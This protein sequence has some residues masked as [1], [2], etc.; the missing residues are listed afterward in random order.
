M[1][2]LSGRI[3]PAAA[4]AAAACFMLITLALPGTAAAQQA[5]TPPVF[6]ADQPGLSAGSMV[7]AQA[8]GTHTATS[9]SV[10]VFD[11]T[12]LISDDDISTLQSQTADIDFPAEVTKVT[13][14]LFGSNDDNLNDTV[15]AHVETTDQSLISDNREKF[16]PGTLIIAIGLD[17]RRVGIYGGD[18]V[19]TAIDY[20][21]KGRELGIQ[22]PMKNVLRADG[23]PNFALA[24][25]AGAKAAADPQAVAESS[26]SSDGGDGPSGWLIGGGI[27]GFAALLAGIFGIDR[28]MRKDKKV[29]QLRGDIKEVNSNYAAVAMDL[30]SIDIR[31]QQLSSPL[32]TAEIRREWETVKNKFAATHD[33]VGTLDGLNARSD[34][35]ALYERRDDIDTV[36][37]ATEEMMAAKDNIDI[38]F[39]L[40]KGDAATRIAQV[41]DLHND[42]T[43]AAMSTTDSQMADHFRDIDGKVLA[44]RSDPEAPDFMDRYCAVLADYASAVQAAKTRDMEELVR[45]EKDDPSSYRRPGLADRQWRPGYGY[46]DFVFYSTMSTW[47]HEAH[48]ARIEAES[49][50]S[51]SGTTSG[52]SSG[53]FSGGG[54]SSSW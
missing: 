7:Q 53:G 42:V 30:D 10:V 26:R 29:K 34:A 27:A 52:Y 9:L 48:E 25:L 1:E 45:A 37:E 22:N 16:A 47:N 13:Y 5:M 4:R 17:P 54:S 46:R 39:N 8:G 35:D 3:I 20:Y 32:A 6:V 41:N 28:K 18:D 49:S 2:N 43:T 19:L 44:L 51:S 38:L 36:H 50:S 11:R 15:R 21:A 14:L 12:G 40:E 31:A 24:F 23:D 33:I